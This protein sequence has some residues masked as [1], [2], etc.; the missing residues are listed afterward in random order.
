[1][2]VMYV[3]LCLLMSLGNVYHT[4]NPGAIAP[5]YLQIAITKTKG[6]LPEKVYWAH[7]C[8]SIFSTTIVPII[9]RSDKHLVSNAQCTDMCMSSY[10][11]SII[12]SQ[13]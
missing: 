7:M 1:M 9:F 12:S 8:T 6:R 10:E 3:Q 11:G 2:P 5:F 4:L 13:L